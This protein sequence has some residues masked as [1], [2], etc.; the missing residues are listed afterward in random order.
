MYGLPRMEGL[1]LRHLTNV[2]RVLENTI[3]PVS[4]TEE[5]NEIVAYIEA[6]L[7]RV[8]SSLI[9]EW[10]LMRNPD[11][12]VNVDDGD[13][14]PK[15]TRPVDI[16]QSK[17]SFTRL[18]RNEV[19]G[20]VSLLA[21]KQYQEIAEDYE[22]DDLFE[23]GSEV[24]WK[25]LELEKLMGV[26]YETRDWI[27]LDPAARSKEHTHISVADDGKA[28]TVEQ[29]L[30]DSEELNDWLVEF[31]IDLERSRETEQVAFRL[32]RIGPLLV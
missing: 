11:Y 26:F 7:R 1:L 10:E 28:W 5:V 16:T 31:E 30:V 13:E 6:L 15:R 8:D 4:K 24:K 17:E 29:T 9:D 19:F 27:R 21:N 2:Y 3:P 14:L 20:F 18:I 22:L 32:K 23:V 25:D 12:E